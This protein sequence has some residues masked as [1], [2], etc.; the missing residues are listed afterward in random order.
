MP[1]RIH[2]AQLLIVNFATALVCACAVTASAHHAFGGEFDSTKPVVLKGPI[3][4]VE[5][6]NP[7]AWIHV[8]ITKPDGADPSEA[9]KGR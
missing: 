3:M 4:K 7:H 6:V 9:T 5:W 2:H 1:A 8:Q